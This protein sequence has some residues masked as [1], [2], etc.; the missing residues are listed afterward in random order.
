MG[1]GSLFPASYYTN[2]T[3]PIVHNLPIGSSKPGG[4]HSL[5]ARTSLSE[6]T[7]AFPHSA[8]THASLTGGFVK[9]C[10]MSVWT[11]LDLAYLDFNAAGVPFPISSVV[12]DLMSRN[13][14]NQIAHYLF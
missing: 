8:A 2:S 7:T 1:W 12:S 3:S 4:V 14:L 5:Q 6:K 11:E 10:F 9:A 13:H